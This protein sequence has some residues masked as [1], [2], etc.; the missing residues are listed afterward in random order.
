M[1]HLFVPYEL[2]VKLKEK[3]F[4]EPC[5]AVYNNLRNGHIDLLSK[6]YGK[7]EMIS[8]VAA[9]LY[10]QVVDWL[11]EKYSLC[12]WV[13]K[14]WAGEINYI[15]YVEGMYPIEK[16]SDGNTYYEALTKVIKKVLKLI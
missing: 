4:N 5:F 16:E 15:G 6:R 14:Q 9:P 2:A 11:R 3:G 1:K 12:V 8:L 7:N 13:N 10:Q